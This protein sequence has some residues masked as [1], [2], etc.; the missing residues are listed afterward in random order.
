MEPIVP[1]YS[2]PL[3]KESS[4]DVHSLKQLRAWISSRSEAYKA[5]LEELDVDHTFNTSR[6]AGIQYVSNT[7]SYD[8][9]E[10]FVQEGNGPNYFGGLYTLATCRHDIRGT[11]ERTG[12]WNFDD[13]FEPVVGNTDL[14]LPK[15]PVLVVN[16]TGKV[17]DG[18]RSGRWI[19]SIAFVTH[20]FQTME[21]Y[22]DHLLSE[23]NAETV[24]NRLTRAEDAPEKAIKH[25]DCHA[26]YERAT[27]GPPEGH[28][29]HEGTESTCGCGSADA[30]LHSDNDDD[31]LKILSMEE[32][33][34]SFDKPVFENTSGGRG[35]GK[36]GSLELHQ[37]SEVQE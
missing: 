11:T 10:G 14:W 22:A 27:G 15:Y 35:H 9:T 30:K 24:S 8:L 37:I 28:P 5:Y 36:I 3:G 4:A 32:F 13:H 19:P 34:L 17:S 20:A 23:Y 29:H 7:I 6:I 25:G 31:H 2:I 16:S 18:H 33:W 26:N 12:G 1:G 21:G